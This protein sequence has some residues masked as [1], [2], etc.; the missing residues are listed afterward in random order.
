MK[1]FVN[2]SLLALSLLILGN[3]FFNSCDKDNNDVEAPLIPL[4][5]N[6]LRFDKDG[7]LAEMTSYQYDKDRRLIRV[8]P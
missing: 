2:S 5:S 7:A 1:T 3:L 4:L 6:M 8:C